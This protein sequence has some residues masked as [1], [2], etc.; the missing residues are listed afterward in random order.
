MRTHDTI[1]Y[2]GCTINVHQ[3]ETPENPFESWDCEPP[4]LTYYGGRHGYFKA[5]GEIEDLR[6]IIA[7]LPDS[8]FERG[9]RVKFW[10][11]YVGSTY[12]LRDVAEMKRDSGMTTREAIENLILSS[13]GYKPDGW[14]TA[15]EW[16]EL[17]E[18]LLSLAG[19]PCY[20]GQSNGYC[21]G[22]STLVLAIA[23]PSWVKL[24]GAPESSLKAQCKGAF[25]LYSSWAWGDVYGFTLEDESGEEINGSCWGF[26]GSDHKESGLLEAAEGD[27]DSHLESQAKESESLE[28]ALC[29]FA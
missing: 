22:D 8:I 1:Q 24:V 23:A 21:Q 18:S 11:E 17:A 13:W 6:D 3:D 26:Y 15:C 25:D 19:I 2:K 12:S 7:I 14:R 27:V 29:S 20:Q 16:M 4:L 10:R 28:S 5:Y 9:E